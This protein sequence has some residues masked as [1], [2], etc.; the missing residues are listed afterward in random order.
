MNDIYQNMLSAYDTSTDQGRRN[1][2]FEV[3]QQVILA[4]L[5]QG[6]FFEDAAFYGGTCLRLFHGLPRFSE[7]MDFS[8]MSPE[9]NFDFTR[10]FQ[11]IIEQF[12][13]LGRKV[14][15]TK[16]G[17]GNFGKVESAFLKD[18][19]EVYD[20]KFRTEK[21]VRI[22]IEVDTQPPLKFNTEQKLLLQPISFMNRCFT[23]P[24]LFAGKMH[25]LVFRTWKNRVK[26]RDWYD[27]EWYVRHNV[28]LDWTYLHE[29]IRQ[30]NGKDISQEDFKSLLEE[31]LAS[32]DVKKVKK[33][34]L[35]FIKN[36]KDLDIW[37]NA[38][39]LQLADLVKFI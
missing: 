37:S 23:L 28:S 13:Y 29:R 7:D 38:Y 22:K 25:A 33:D 14:D 6:G 20:V 1:A 30:F 26:G 16:K 17:K 35:P 3:S 24:D 34:V 2:V 15:I 10:F 18:N 36:P 12:N 11:P 21:S 4:G 27:F 32:T 31:R 5:Y 19:T 8:L 9:E 39:F